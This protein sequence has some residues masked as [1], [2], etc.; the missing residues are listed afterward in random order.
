MLAIIYPQNIGI[1]DATDE[2]L[3]AFCHMWKCYGYFLG[4]ED[5]YNFCRGSFKEI[6]QRLCDLDQHWIKINFTDVT[7]E[8]MYIIRN[9]TESI[10]YYPYLYMTHKIMTLFLAESL[11]LEMPNLY[12]SLKYGEWIAYNIYKF[13][14][15][16]AAKFSIIKRIVNLLFYKILQ[17]ASN[18]GPETLAKLQEKSKQYM[19][20]SNKS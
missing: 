13:F 14:F 20:F 8:W 1:H 9:I 3:E 11:N 6:K 15:N 18:F 19:D 17:T 2:D 12:A 7:S 10:N 5:E 16:H 4:I